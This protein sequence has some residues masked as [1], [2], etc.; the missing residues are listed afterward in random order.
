MHIISKNTSSSGNL[1]WYSDSTY[2]NAQE[3]HDYIQ[4]KRVH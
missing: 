1:L 2:K 4:F 3:K